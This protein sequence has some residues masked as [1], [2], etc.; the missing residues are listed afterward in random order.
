MNKSQRGAV[1]VLLAFSVMLPFAQ[2]ATLVSSAP[3]PVA[4]TEAAEHLTLPRPTGPYTVGQ[5][6]LHLTDTS[7][8]DPWVPRAGARQILVSMHYPARPR[9]G[10]RTV[11]YMREDETRE[12]MRTV[13]SDLVP[14]GSERL[15]AAM[16]TWSRQD[17]RPVKGRFPLVV[18]SPGFGAPRMTLTLLAEDLASRGYVVASLDHA[19]ESTATA[20]P[21]RGV[22]SCV[23]C[24]EDES[25]EVSEVVVE[26]RAKDVSF[27]L[28][29]LTGPRPAWNHAE[30]IDSRR[31]GMA[32]HSI[33]GAAT[34]RTMATDARVDAGVNMDGSF[35]SPIPQRGLGGRPFLMLGAEDAGPGSGDRSWDTAWKRLDG[36]KRWLTVIGSDHY[37]FSD[38][39]ALLA[40][41]NGTP[42]Q[43]GS[44]SGKR[45]ARI[46][47]TFVAAFFDRHLKAANR[48]V[49]NGPT[50]TTPEVLFRRP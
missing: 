17:A 8:P 25:K 4:G 36:W 1:A 20:F 21:G 19:F 44:L 33:G 43:P 45:S 16:R 29:R 5:S 13:L 41:I 18:L 12:L 46:T 15:L 23:A 24:D 32:G 38:A 48:P 7:R 40:Q 31:I 9:T 50:S 22:L 3:G 10:T 30:M 26:G 27:V 14:P 28:D 34:A 42:D 47:R 49:L 35:F 11:R 2:V 37:T 39:P 6:A